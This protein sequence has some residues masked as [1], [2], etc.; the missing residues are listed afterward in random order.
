MSRAPLEGTGGV[1]NVSCVPC[2]G[3]SAA[4]LIGL[5]LPYVLTL[6]KKNNSETALSR[7]PQAFILPL[8]APT[9]SYMLYRVRAGLE[10]QRFG[11]HC[12]R[13]LLGWGALSELWG[14]ATCNPKAGTKAQRLIDL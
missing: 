2:F 3:F 8:T 1:K 6:L 9:L 10:N 4:F 11:A 14:Y 13:R 5:A 7:A 12:I